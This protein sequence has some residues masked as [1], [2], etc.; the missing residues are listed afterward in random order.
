MGCTDETAS[1]FNPQAT[2]EDGSCT[3]CDLVLS[4]SSVLSR[5]LFRCHDG[6]AQFTVDSALTDSVILHVVR[7]GRC[8][9][10]FVDW[11]AFDALMP[12]NYVLEV[13]DRGFDLQRGTGVH[14]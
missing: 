4:P 6:T 13:F 1:N 11:I 9:D 8:D 2:V 5:E 14:D 7:T 3:Y 12:G 10:R